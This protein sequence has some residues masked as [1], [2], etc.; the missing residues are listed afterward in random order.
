MDQTI[1][2]PTLGWN[3]LRLVS[4]AQAVTT[5]LLILAATPTRWWIVTGPIFVVGCIAAILAIVQCRVIW[6]WL[7]MLL[8]AALFGVGLF[9]TVFRISDETYV[10]LLLLAFL[11]AIASEHVLSV[12][13]NYSAQF[14]R[15]GTRTVTEFNAQA[16]RTSLGNLYGMLAWDAVIFGGVFLISLIVASLGAVGATITMLSDPSLYVALMSITLAFLFVL[17]EEQ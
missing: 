12:T 14:S 11:M 2:Q 17:K 5:Y 13:L 10:P 15:R 8:Q 7:T 9:S 6:A 3:L 1:R 16:L 4:A